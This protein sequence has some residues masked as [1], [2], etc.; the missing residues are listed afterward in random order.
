MNGDDV[1]VL[2][3]LV[4]PGMLGLI[5]GRWRFLLVVGVL[6][7]GYA[8]FAIERYG[9]DWGEFGIELTVLWVLLTIVSAALGIGVRKAAGSLRG[10][11]Q[12]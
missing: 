7:I 2:V 12:A 4:A 8:V 6:C 11:A 10:R 1:L 5:V 3:I 9:N